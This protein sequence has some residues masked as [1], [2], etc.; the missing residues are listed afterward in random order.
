MTLWTGDTLSRSRGQV[1]RDQHWVTSCEEVV[2]FGW[3]R[4]R[5]PALIG[6]V[7]GCSRLTSGYLL[8]VARVSRASSLASVCTGHTA[9]C[10][11]LSST[12]CTLADHSH[13]KLVI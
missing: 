4:R 2:E 8:T 9:L 10:V 5:F 13:R 6:R 1:A 12:E 11:S 3:Q 7:T